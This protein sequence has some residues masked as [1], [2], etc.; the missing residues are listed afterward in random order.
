VWISEINW[1]SGF[2]AV[3]CEGCHVAANFGISSSVR[4]CYKKKVNEQ[5]IKWIK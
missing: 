5:I 4:T 2:S 3:S 1:E